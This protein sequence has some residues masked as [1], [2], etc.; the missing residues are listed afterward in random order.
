MIKKKF[1]IGLIL[2]L[3]Y[4]VVFCQ[5]NESLDDE[6]QIAAQIDDGA[7]S[8][9]CISASLDI[10]KNGQNVGGVR[11]DCL[12]EYTYNLTICDDCSNGGFW[13]GVNTCTHRVKVYFDGVELASL[14]LS[15]IHNSGGDGD[16]SCTT[17]S[18]SMADL[19]LEDYGTPNIVEFN[20][21]IE[22]TCFYDLGDVSSGYYTTSETINL[23]FSIH[24]DQGSNVYTRI[25]RLPSLIEPQI[26]D[27]FLD[28]PRLCCNPDSRIDYNY[29]I[30]LISTYTQETS[31]SGTLTFSLG[32][33]INISKPKNPIY[34]IDL[35]G[36]IVAE[37]AVSATWAS[38]LQTNKSFNVDYRIQGVDDGCVV[39]GLLLHKVAYVE[40][41]WQTN[42]DGEDELIETREFFIP[43]IIEPFPCEVEVNT[44]CDDLVQPVPEKRYINNY[45]RSSNSECKGE[46]D[47]NLDSYEGLSIGWTGP[48]GFQS[49]D[50]NLT[51]LQI[52]TY[53]YTIS[54][55]CC[56][57]VEGE[58]V[59]CGEY[60]Y[61]PWFNN[62]DGQFCRNVR[63]AD[64]PTVKAN[65]SECEFEECVS[66]DNVVE[67]WDGTFCI[68]DYYYEGELLA[69]EPSNPDINI[70]YD[71]FTQLCVKQTM[72]L[73]SVVAEE[74]GFPTYGFWQYDE[75]E[76]K[77]IRTITCFDELMEEPDQKDPVIE[78][79]YDE[80]TGLCEVTVYCETT[81]FYLPPHFPYDIGDWE[82]TEFNGCTQDIQ[83]SFNGDIETITGD[84]D[85]IN[86]TYDDFIGECQ[87]NVECNGNLV[88]GA[89][90]TEWPQ[91]IGAWEYA[92]ERPFEEQCRRAVWC[93]GNLV[94]QYEAP[95]FQDGDQCDCESGSVI[96][97]ILTFCGDTQV[98][99]DPCFYPCFTE[100]EEEIG[101]R[102]NSDENSIH[103][104]P[105]PVSNYL[106]ISGLDSEKS[107]DIKVT[108]IMG[109]DISNYK[110]SSNKIDLTQLAEGLYFI[111]ILESGKMIKTQKIIKTN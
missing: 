49:N 82:W 41:T 95:T 46:I 83:C 90:H 35:G 81:P 51:D 23:P 67:N 19:G 97:E 110:L 26:I 89:I 93:S 36:T 56:E 29:G 62:G 72:C 17:V 9:P 58:V 8:S 92:T 57:T 78:E 69:S 54:N 24:G 50:F 14:S 63:C 87:A 16:R 106:F 12:E 5:G 39:V 28:G 40:E 91:S 66:P 1:L 65:S 53:S 11:T 86:W 88:W 6:L 47:I 15:D 98:D 10:Q 104:S 103:F 55:E 60:I 74:T 21:V 34:S 70:S 68:L 22:T 102:N 99:Y 45:E 61:D 84:E 75:F 2:L 48:N 80:F 79:V 44:D 7:A 18:G 43:D 32:G 30:N 85:F 109:K 59:F 71:N 27:C 76:E 101:L 38:S 52:G 94:Y 25:F 100:E 73:G 20:V 111:S 64:L 77:C 42:C 37:V 4:A 3:N 107:Y 108:D 33:S 96:Y 31:V 13:A 105:N